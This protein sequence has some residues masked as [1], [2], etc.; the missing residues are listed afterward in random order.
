[1]EKLNKM[2]MASFTASGRKNLIKRTDIVGR[3]GEI[4][5]SKLWRKVDQLGERLYKEIRL[6]EKP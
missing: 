2:P 4:D 5:Y 6:L 1:M 3:N